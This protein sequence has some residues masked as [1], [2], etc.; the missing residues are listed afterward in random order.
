[1]DGIYG[2]WVTFLTQMREQGFNAILCCSLGQT[3]GR[4]PELQV[5]RHFWRQHIRYPYDRS[6]A[7]NQCSQKVFHLPNLSIK[8]K[9]TCLHFRVMLELFFIFL[10]SFFRPL[11]SPWLMF[12]LWCPLTLT[13]PR[14]LPFTLCLQI[15]RSAF[16][17]ACW[18][19]PIWFT[20][21]F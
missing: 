10:P 4:P 2:V 20:L 14:H 5:R 1:M 18:A 3:S 9:H 7:E 16:S 8:H 17:L 21:S 19:M 12:S 6:E 11:L 15:S 13:Y